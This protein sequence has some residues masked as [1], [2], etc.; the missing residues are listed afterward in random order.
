MSMMI[1]RTAKTKNCLPTLVI[2]GDAIRLYDNEQWQNRFEIRSESSKKTY[3]VSQHK[4]SKH[5]ACSCPGWKFRRRCK[6]LDR[7]GL[8]GDE[9]PYEVGELRPAGTGQSIKLADEKTAPS[10]DRYIT[11]DDGDV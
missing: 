11:W 7:F 9:R 2:P 1:A 8:P 10:S 3:I 6:H 4:D 5:W